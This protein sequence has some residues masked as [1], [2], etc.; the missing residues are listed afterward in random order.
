VT[1]VLSLVNFALRYDMVASGFQLASP[2]SEV[3][4]SARGCLLG[5]D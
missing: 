1:F 5:E 3:W 4:L 2:S